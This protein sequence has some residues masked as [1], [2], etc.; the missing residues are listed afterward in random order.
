MFALN[1]AG[2]FFILV[3]LLSAHFNI[4]ANTPDPLW[5]KAILNHQQAKK[6]AAK[7]VLQVMTA[8]KDGETKTKTI[9]KQLDVWE[10]DKAKY[11]VIS[12]EPPTTNATAK[13]PLD[14]SEMTESTENEFFTINTKVIRTDNLVVD[15]QACV[16]FEMENSVGK[17]AAWVDAKTGKIIQKQVEMS[18]PMAMEGV[19][20]TKY[21]EQTGV[22]LPQTVTTLFEV[23]IPLKK[24]KI[25]MKETYTNWVKHE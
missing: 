12:I 10:G 3:C 8:T 14:L 25:E 21:T 7:D 22:S 5:E 11:K 20:L 2:R 13:K 24:A 23:K 15:K 18:V 9:T 6:W 16:K 19:V 1:K 4:S 17:F